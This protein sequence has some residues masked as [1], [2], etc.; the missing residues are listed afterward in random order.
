MNSL[1][2]FLEDI[3]VKGGVEDILNPTTGNK[4][5]HKQPPTNDIKQVRKMEQLKCETLHNVSKV[6]NS[7]EGNNY[8]NSNISTIIS[9][10]A[11]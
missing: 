3:S 8:T 5:L 2:T 9:L 7:L 10:S 6:N 11:T 1:S 4:S